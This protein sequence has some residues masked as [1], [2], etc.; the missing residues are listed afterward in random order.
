MERP[1]NGRK[2][3]KLKISAFCSEEQKEPA[4][5]VD[6]SQKNLIF[7]GNFF[8]FFEI[9]VSKKQKFPEPFKQI[10]VFAFTKNC[11]FCSARLRRPRT[12]QALYAKTL[13]VLLIRAERRVKKGKKMNIEQ[14]TRKFLARKG[15]FQFG[16]VNEWTAKDNSGIP[17]FHEGRPFAKMNLLETVEFYIR[18][19]ETPSMK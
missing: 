1:K 8:C 7:S 10:R 4:S 12:A 2:D 16:T 5:S 13:R 18:P 6:C 9:G 11:V 3:F 14:K 15:F 19:Y 17:W